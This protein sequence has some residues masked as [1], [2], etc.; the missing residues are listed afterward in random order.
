MRSFVFD[1]ESVMAKSRGPNDVIP[2]VEMTGPKGLVVVNDEPDEIAERRENGYTFTDPKREQAAKQQK[3]STRATE[4]SGT[5]AAA[6]RKHDRENKSLRERQEELNDEMA[7]F[8]KDNPTHP[9]AV[10]WLE[11]QAKLKAGSGVQPSVDDRQTA[12]AKTVN[13]R[14][15][16]GEGDSVTPDPARTQG[17]A[18]GK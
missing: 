18:Q 8:A 4:A 3:K 10:L 16:R 13:I 5:S 6:A 14:E 15:G 1:E 11:D 12:Q 17:K 2:T 9:D 7:Q